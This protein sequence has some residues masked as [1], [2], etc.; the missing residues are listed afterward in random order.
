M[1]SNHFESIMIIA[2]KRKIKIKILKCTTLVLHEVMNADGNGM[3]R[4]IYEFPRNSMWF[5]YVPIEHSISA[6]AQMD[7]D[8]HVLL[9]TLASVP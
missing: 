9:C 5:L 2:L 8:G 6:I 1:C 4:L 7:L 3:G